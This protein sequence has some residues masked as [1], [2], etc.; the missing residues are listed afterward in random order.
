MRKLKRS[1]RIAAIIRM[2]SSE[3]GRV[4][5]LRE[6]SEQ[7][8]CAKSTLSED[9]S[10][11]RTALCECKLGIVE[12][13][14]GAA[15]GVRFYPFYDDASDALF[16]EELCKTLSHSSRILPGNLLFTAD[17]FSD[18]KLLN[19][20]GEILAKAFFELNPDILV[21]LEVS[22]APIALMVAKALGKPLAI[23]RRSSR[24]AEGA[25]VTLSLPE[26]GSSRIQ[27]LSLPTRSLNK[28]QRA[29]IIDDCIESGATAE[30]LFALISEFGA[31]VCG[32]GTIMA[33]SV[34]EV[35]RVEGYLHLISFN[36]GSK[37]T[38]I[39]LAPAEWLFNSS[40]LAGY[41]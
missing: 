3:P 35:K 5:T 13:I 9:I 39:E 20:L 16:V 14:N 23:A 24:L 33:A 1:E 27:Q 6:F 21:T 2:L 32:L 15:G 31:K 22:G 12:S 37:S 36:K 10:L 40:T 8:G 28:G 41:A 17:V 19:R 29:L 26:S 7:F 38:G 11:L 25:T 30:A 34:P 4:F 18:P